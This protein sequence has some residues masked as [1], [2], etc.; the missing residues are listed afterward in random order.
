MLTVRPLKGLVS[1][2]FLS[3]AAVGSLGSLWVNSEALAQGGSNYCGLPQLNFQQT[4]YRVCPDLQVT[5]AELICMRHVIASRG[6][7]N[8]RR[9]A[10]R[11]IRMSFS[12][13]WVI[14]NEGFDPFAGNLEGLVVTFLQQ[15]GIL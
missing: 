14:A 8:D 15:R 1:S 5:K 4:V 10:D 11:N 7:W 13:C 9:N 3:L 12:T 6:L 2:L